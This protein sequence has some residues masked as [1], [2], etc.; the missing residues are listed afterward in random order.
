M[1][2]RRLTPDE[3]AEKSQELATAVNDKLLLEDEKKE[4]NADFAA[5]KKAIDKRV[6]DLTAT[7]RSK[8]VWESDQRDMFRLHEPAEA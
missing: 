2:M 3:L 1:P 4:K 5:R 7:V 6:I 8:Q